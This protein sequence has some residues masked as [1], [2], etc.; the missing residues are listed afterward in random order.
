MHSKAMKRLSGLVIVAAFALSVSAS[1]AGAAFG[2]L[3][4]D[5]QITANEGGSPFTQANGHPYEISTEIKLNTYEDLE[6][7]REEP[8]LEGIERPEGDVKDVITELPPG[9]FGDPA[10]VAQCTATQLIAPTEETPFRAPE[11]PIASQVGIVELN[12]DIKKLLPEDWTFPLYNMVPPPNAPA[13]FGFLVAG[14]P[15]TLVGNVRNSGDYGITIVSSDVTVALPFNGINVIFWGDPAD[16]SHDR[17][18]CDM[19]GFGMSATGGCPGASGTAGGPNVSPVQPQA[20]LTVPGSCPSASTGMKTTLKVDSWV[21]P[22][23]F[24]EHSIVNHLAPGFPDSESDWGAEQ[25]MTGCELEPFNPSVS[26]AP[27]NA[28][29]DTPSGLNVEISLPQEGLLNTE[30]IATADVKDAVVTLPAGE[31]ISPSAAD[32]LEGCTTEQIGLGSGQPAACPDGSKLGSVEIDTPLLTEP[33]TGSIFLG[34]PECGPCNVSDDQEGRLVKLYIVAEGHG[35]ILKLPGRVEMDPVTGQIKTTFDN[36]PQLP[37]D[38]LKLDFKAGPRS[39]LVNPH[40]CG[41]Y[42]TTATLTPWSGQ[43][44]AQTSSTFKITSGPNGAP[45]P[46][47][48][49]AFAPGFSAGTVN[50]QAGVFSPFTLTFTRADGEQQ[51]GGVTLKMPPGLLGTLAGIP[52]CPEPQASQGTCA[53]ASEIGSVST[54]AGAGANPFL[55]TGGK[56]FLT[57]GY[58]GGS[59]GLAIVVPAVA[60]PFNLGQVV[61]RASI[62]I[63][64][65]TAQLT[66]SSD[67]LPTILDGIPLDLRTVNVAIDRPGFTFNPTS[68]DQMSLVGTLTGGAGG[69][70]PVSSSFQATNCGVLGFKPS[71]SASTAAKTSRAKGASLSVKLGFPANA[72]GRQANIRSVK[73]ELPKRLP[74][75]LST[76]QN[77]CTAATFEADPEAC[78]ATSRIGTASASTPILP[79]PL[80]G[81]VY[82]VSHGGEAFPN[83]VMVL[84]GYGVTVELVGDTFISKAGITSTTFK[85]IPD[86]P[87]RSFALTLPEGRYS[88]LAA[89]GNLCNAT[90]RMPTEIVGQNSTRFAQDTKIK[91]TGC[92]AQTRKRHKRKGGDRKS[93][94]HATGHGQK[95]E[96]SSSSRRRR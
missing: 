37:F 66:V 54:V 52:L 67:P 46:S 45:C 28:Q 48:P 34:K 96:G 59:F 49:Q 93:Q 24:R 56:V 32:G 81:T 71:F 72:M 60:G 91:V 42:T 12:V 64:P 16:K 68:C 22:G 31:A 82:F 1:P 18:R 55:V 83:L 90:L 43:E 47:S 53:V 36:N 95:G 19:G 39:P 94:S 44:A 86:V 5:Q 10:D 21:E 11:C 9:L 70:E 88:A 79:V 61:V 17:F 63:D 23:V 20:F 57:T 3:G 2:I 33:L 85:T 30:G 25:G 92:A 76:L 62:A 29:A 74:S 7:G 84:K 8:E 26:V 78:P 58:K 40:Q 15:I 73:V 4:F 6:V 50:N 51:L 27:T 13:E 41:T 87:V 65:R 35:V 69:V 14:E 80:K 75:R 89:N 77:A 38:H